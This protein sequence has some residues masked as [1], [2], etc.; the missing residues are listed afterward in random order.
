MTG[1]LRRSSF[2]I[3]NDVFED[4]KRTEPMAIDDN[5]HPDWN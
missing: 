2:Q 1:R 5:I 4:L 3:K